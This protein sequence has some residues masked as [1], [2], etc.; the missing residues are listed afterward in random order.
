MAPNLELLLVR[1]AEHT[2]KADMDAFSRL[3]GR[4]NRGSSAR[5]GTGQSPPNAPN[6]NIAKA[7]PSTARPAH[8][9]P[10]AQQVAKPT[11]KESPAQP[12]VQSWP[13]RLESP[14]YKI[15]ITAYHYCVGQ[16]K[17]AIT[18]AVHDIYAWAFISAGLQGVAGGELVF[19]VKRRPHEADKSYPLDFLCICDTIY[20]QASKRRLQLRR[21]GLIDL[22]EPLFNQTGLKTIALGFRNTPLFGMESAGLDKGPIPHFYCLALNDEEVA[23]ARTCGPV[24]AL[25]SAN[26]NSPWF[27]F[28]FYVDRDWKSS[29]SP[30]KMGRS[31]VVGNK[32]NKLNV[33]G[34]N[35]IHSSNGQVTLNIPKD[36]VSA[37][38]EA[39]LVQRFRSGASLLIESEMHDS[40]NGV[41]S[42]ESPTSVFVLAMNPTPTNIAAN[43]LLLAFNQTTEA[44]R[45]TEDGMLGTVTRA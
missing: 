22:D 5:S 34:L 17:D 31:V 43:F 28:P 44:V 26:P 9:L 4:L 45:A 27:P 2:H 19:V 1:V 3:K 23:V 10:M 32:P 33:T 13:I 35:V 18:Q 36:R 24:R 41:Y 11:A 14:R 39:M 20:D 15:R 8:P 29:L 38:K 30:A 42:W 21:W 7:E 37:F 40:C 16:V 25:V 12:L 6:T